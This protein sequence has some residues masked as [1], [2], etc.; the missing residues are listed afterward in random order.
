MSKRNEDSISHLARKNRKFKALCDFI[1]SYKNAIVAY[2][3]GVDSSLLG[4]LCG[5]LLDDVVCIIASSQTYSK[6]EL[7]DAVQFCEKHE[8]AYRV[9]T[10]DELDN[11]QFC[12]ND[13]LRCYHC[14]KTLFGDLYEIKL[15]GDWD[16]V[17]DGTNSDDSGDY[18]PG[19]EAA[20]EFCVVSPLRE[21]GFGKDD[22]RAISRLLGLETWDK[23]QMACLASRVSYGTRIEPDVLRRIEAVE[24]ILRDSGFKDVRARYHGSIVRIEI[25]KNEKVDLG[26]LRRLV[27]A[28]KKA[29]FKYVTLDLEG[30]RAG[31][32]NE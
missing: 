17:F 9:I 24:E 4:F 25:G 30:Y 2:S 31:S 8:I 1:Q 26:K 20:K 19:Y 6:R 3:G 27:P 5:Q 32:M 11:E 16:V 23:P 15:S 22:I 18:R 13:I 21:A 10:T 28:V 7:E 29:G 14:K 12:R